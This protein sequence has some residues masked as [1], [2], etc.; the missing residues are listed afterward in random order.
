MSP[1]TMLKKNVFIWIQ[2]STWTLSDVF[3]SIAFYII[4]NQQK[5]KFHSVVASSV[6]ITV[7]QILNLNNWEQFFMWFFLCVVLLCFVLA[8]FQDLR[9]RIL[10]I[11][12]NRFSTYFE[13]KQIKPKIFKHF[14]RYFHTCLWICS[15]FNHP[16]SNDLNYVFF[17]LQLIFH[18]NLCVC[19][20]V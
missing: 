3:C 10:V 11:W 20:C 4:S 5:K 13:P 2:L 1:L 9:R 14:V 15:S 17:L 6:E 19:V 12:D 7:C 18:P 16:K 8:N